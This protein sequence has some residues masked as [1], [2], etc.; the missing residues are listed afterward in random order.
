MPGRGVP[1]LGP[2]QEEEL[3]LPRLGVAEGHLLLRQELR[4]VQVGDEGH[5]GLPP[6]SLR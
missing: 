4:H 6:L 3:L 1:G 2:A 5:K